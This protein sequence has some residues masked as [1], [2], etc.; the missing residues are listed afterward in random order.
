[1]SAPSPTE[2]PSPGAELGPELV[3]DSRGQGLPGRLSS[4]VLPSQRCQLPG[5]SLDSS[6]RKQLGRFQGLGL[7]RVLEGTLQSSQHLGSAW[8]QGEGVGLL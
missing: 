4:E 2:G 7:R 8:R 3:P 5:L 1:M 6:A